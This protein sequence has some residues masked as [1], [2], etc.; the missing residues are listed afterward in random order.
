[1]LHLETARGL[2]HVEGADHI[3]VDI[4]ARVFEAVAHPGLGGEMHDHIRR[5]GRRR[6]RSSS[7]AS[8]SMPSVAQKSGCCSSMA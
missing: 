1:M 3:A 4:G 8:S 2:H 5:E 7:S 6:P